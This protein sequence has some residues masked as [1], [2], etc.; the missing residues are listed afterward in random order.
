MIQTESASPAKLG[1][2]PTFVSSNTESG[3]PSTRILERE[4]T[5]LQLLLDQ[6]DVFEYLR[7]LNHG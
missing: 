7:K 2:E 3:E 1:V 6:P 4:K 5:K